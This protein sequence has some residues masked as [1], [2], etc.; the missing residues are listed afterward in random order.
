MNDLLPGVLPA[1]VTSILS[2]SS[3]KESI[4][5]FQWP[6]I[7]TKFYQSSVSWASR[8]SYLIMLMKVALEGYRF[9][10]D[11]LSVDSLA[12]EHE[13]V[14]MGL[15]L[16][17]MAIEILFTALELYAARRIILSGSIAACFLNRYAYYYH[18]LQHWSYFCF[19]QAI[20]NSR[21]KKQKLIARLYNVLQRSKFLLVAIF[22]FIL[23]IVAL[24]RLCGSFDDIWSSCSRVNA[25]SKGLI[26][27]KLAE[28]LLHLVALLVSVALYPF[29]RCAIG[30]RSHNLNSYVR[31]RIDKI[32]G[33]LVNKSPEG[34]QKNSVIVSNNDTKQATI[35]NS[36]PHE[37]HKHSVS[38]VNLDSTNN[39]NNSS[40]KNTV[41]NESNSP[42]GGAIAAAPALFA[43]SL[44]E[45][46]G[47]S[48]QSAPGPHGS[49]SSINVVNIYNAPRVSLFQANSSA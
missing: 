35:I 46:S 1:S 44:T 28:L 2:S 39:N 42:A 34:Y 20:D 40:R 22:Q 48:A 24:S 13:T 14:I 8:L 31:S 29:I 11:S 19:F 43:I 23:L 3:T 17:S 15:Y 27:L 45:Q 30:W 47:S 5:Q 18:G 7:N 4:H 36:A 12:R 26:L 21:S 38:N 32:I 6:Q 37:A 25:R 16:G 49:I 9:I 41:N 33:K 10:S